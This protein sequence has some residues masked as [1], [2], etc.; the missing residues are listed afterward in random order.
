MKYKNTN[1]SRIF[2]VVKMFMN[3]PGALNYMNDDGENILHDMVT[4]NNPH[5]LSALLSCNKDLWTK[6]IQHSDRNGETALHLACGH[7]GRYLLFNNITKDQYI[8]CLQMILN[9]SDDI[10]I[11]RKSII[12]RT[13]LHHACKSYNHVA[14]RA[15]LQ[16]PEIKVDIFDH[17]GNTPLL[18]TI[19]SD[20]SNLEYMKRTGV[21]RQCNAG[22]LDHKAWDMTSLRLLLN[23]NECLILAR[24]KSGHHLLDLATN[25]LIQICNLPKPNQWQ[26]LTMDFVNI[27]AELEKYLAKARWKMFQYILNPARFPIKQSTLTQE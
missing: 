18:D 9:V 1:H 11:N 23:Y 25:R 10:T 5:L 13:A 19:Y 3:S 27:I 14:V 21:L 2:K 26:S 8:E 12:G 15:I 6:C 22:Q 24:N 16:H 20:E 7:V 17:C 4:W